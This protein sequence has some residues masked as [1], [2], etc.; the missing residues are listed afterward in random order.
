L[1]RAKTL[2]Q[3]AIADGNPELINTELDAM[4]A[5][6]PAQIQAA[7]K[8]F[9]TPDK[10]AVMEIVPAPNPQSGESGQPKEGR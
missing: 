1:S 3:Y 9:L 6:T 4:L 8:K 7:A 5:V 2:A 10:R